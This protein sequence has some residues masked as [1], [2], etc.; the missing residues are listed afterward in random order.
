MAKGTVRKIQPAHK[1]DNI[2]VKQAQQAWQKVEMK[3]SGHTESKVAQGK[4]A[5]KKSANSKAIK[6]T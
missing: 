3:S 1:S 2:T 4:Q 5:H 6:N